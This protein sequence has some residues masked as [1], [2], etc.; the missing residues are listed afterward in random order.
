MK[1]LFSFKSVVRIMS[2]LLVFEILFMSVACLV[3]FLYNESDVRYF[4]YSIGITSAASLLGFLFTLKTRITMGKREGFLVVAT[5]WIV[6]S[7][8]GMLPFY[9]SG[10]IPSFTDAFF[11]TMSGFS[12]TGATILNDI[13]TLSHGQLFWRSLLQWIGGMGIIVLSLAI[14]PLLDV[15]GMSLFA[16]EVPGPTKDK[17]HP[18]LSTTAKMLWGMYTL[19]TFFESF[20]LWVGGMDYFD[21]I[22]HSFTTMATGG[23]STKNASI[24]YWDSPV[25]EYIVIFFMFIGGINF[26]LFFRLL[27]GKFSKVFG[28]EELRF[29]VRFIIILTIMASGSLYYYHSNE[30][31][32]ADNLRYNLFHVVSLITTSGFCVQD[33]MQW[34]PL[35]WSVMLTVMIFSGCS[36]STSGGIKTVRLA[37][38]FKNSYY[39][40]KR[41]LHPNAV[42]PIRFNGQVIRPQLVNSILAFVSLY[43]ILVF[44]SSLVFT[45]TGLPFDESLSTALS[46]VG[47]IGPA[48]G[49][50][51]PASNFST[52]TPF[53]KWFMA[54]LML[55]GRLEIFTVLVVFTPAFWKR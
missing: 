29:Y 47:N 30:I 55:I 41:L 9:L 51:G 25:I 40:F 46:G 6:F 7:A 26:A 37:I 52:L 54:F 2:M 28:D 23:F 39:E 49:S 43:A 27:R 3:S 22:C 35:V 48:I 16:A 19:I 8:F 17:I 13:E 34:Q 44:G 32:L 42:L 50:L 31:S 21:A 1:Q 53:A 45:A 20:C 14:L 15:G 33:Y 12:T 5:V 10:S 18:K 11:E 24:G 4:L 36:G 38:L